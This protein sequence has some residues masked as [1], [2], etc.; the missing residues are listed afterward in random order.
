M[1]AAKGLEADYGV[2]LRI[3]SGRYR[4]PTEMTDDPLLDLVLVAPEEHPNAEERR[5]AAPVPCDERP[6]RAAPG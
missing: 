1:H 2:V 6:V 4:F 5:H 3:C